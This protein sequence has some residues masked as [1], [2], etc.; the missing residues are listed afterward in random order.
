MPP[1]SID[2]LCPRQSQYWQP[3]REGLIFKT[4]RS[5][6]DFPSAQMVCNS[7]LWQYH[8][9]RVVDGNGQIV[10]QV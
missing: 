1:F 10:Y 9:A 5:F 2:Y 4:I 8:A 6:S 3:L 7:L